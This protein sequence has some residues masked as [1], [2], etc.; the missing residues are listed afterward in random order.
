M[1]STERPALSSPSRHRPDTSGVKI[2]RI[3]TAHRPVSRPGCG[4]PIHMMRAV[5]ATSAATAARPLRCGG[6]APSKYSTRNCS[7]LSSRRSMRGQ[8]AVDAAPHLRADRRAREALGQRVGHAPPPVR[9]HLR[10]AAAHRELAGVRADHGHARHASGP[11]GSSP[12]L[13]SR[14][15][16]S[17]ATSRATARRPGSSSSR[18]SVLGAGRVAR[19]RPPG[20]ISRSTCRTWSS[21]TVSSTTP[22]RTAAARVGP[23]PGRGARHLEVEAGQR[24][25]GRRVGPEPV[26]HDQPVEAPLAPEDPVDQVGLLAAVGAVD[27]VVGGHHR[28]HAGLP[29]GGL[30]GDEVDLPQRALGDLGADGHPL[31]LL[32]VAGEVLDAA[33]DPTALHPPH[34]GDG[35]AGRQQR[36]LGEGLE[37]PSGQRRPH[38]ADRR[39]E[40]DV[41]ALGARLGGQHP[42]QA[43]HQRRVPGRPDGHAAGQRQRAPPDQAVAPHARRAVGHLERP[44]AEPLDRGEVPHV[45]AGGE[46][47]LLVE[48]QG[49]DE[50]LDL[51]RGRRSVLRHHV[52]TN[53]RRRRPGDVHSTRGPAASSACT[54]RARVAAGSIT[55]SISKCSATC[56]AL[57]CS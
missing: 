7:P 53:G 19:A 23:E 43:S 51:R 13:T 36:V 41:D 21:T 39:P 26:R 54:K 15:V 42:A 34:V 29:H 57:P 56:S 17:A 2:P 14:T 3:R 47:A 16:P 45:G 8:P 12:S 22:S 25:R 30:E 35:Q 49:P 37:G 46:G 18:S 32:V 40:Q 31:V 1:R 52:S 4:G 6:S 11:S 5:W 44:D 38:D 24:G 10:A 27:L 28:P 48:G 20:R 50:A 55:S 33:P 9:R